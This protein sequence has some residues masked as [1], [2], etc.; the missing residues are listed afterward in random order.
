MVSKAAT[1]RSSSSGAGVRLAVFHQVG[2]G[3]VAPGA[4]EPAPAR[5]HRSTGRDM[6]TKAG[7]VRNV[8]RGFSKNRALS[9]RSTSILSGPACSGWS[10][11]TI[12]K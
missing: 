8:L 2:T 9:D 6:A 5:L 12:W 1:G 10:A 4:E 3:R 11:R 7:P